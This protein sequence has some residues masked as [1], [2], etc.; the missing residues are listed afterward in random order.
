VATEGGLLVVIRVVRLALSAV[1]V[2]RVGLRIVR[3]A[4][5]IFGRAIRAVRNVTLRD[6]LV[7]I[8]V[9]DIVVGLVVVLRDYGIEVAGG[10][11]ESVVAAAL[12]DVFVDAV[13]LWLCETLAL[14]VGPLKTSILGITLDG[15]IP[16]DVVSTKLQELRRLQELYRRREHTS[17]CCRRGSC[18]APPSTPP[19]ALP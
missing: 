9:V 4:L 14:P 15:L 12:A 10:F 16:I 7:D 6:V 8:L 3:A 1:S 11:T 17:L 5:S 13:N 19:S 2:V 18:S